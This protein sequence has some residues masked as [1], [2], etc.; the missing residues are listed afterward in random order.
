M[1]LTNTNLNAHNDAKICILIFGATFL[2]STF[3]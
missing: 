3:L 2:Y 1:F